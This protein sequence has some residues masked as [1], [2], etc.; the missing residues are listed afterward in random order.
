MRNSRMTTIATIAAAVSFGSRRLMKSTFR[1]DFDSNGMQII[2]DHEFGF[3]KETL[4]APVP[5][6]AIMLG[7]TPPPPR[8]K[9]ASYCFGLFFGFHPH[10]WLL[11]AYDSRD[12]LRARWSASVKGFG[13]RLLRRLG[14]RR[15]RRSKASQGGNRGEVGGPFGER[16]YGDLRIADGWRARR[17]RSATLGIFSGSADGWGF[18]WRRCAGGRRWPRSQEDLRPRPGVALVFRRAAGGGGDRRCAAGCG[19]TVMSCRS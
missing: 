12:V 7:R 15:G 17:L 18:R 19:A 4:V 13:R 11:M 6:V 3:L 2:W 8:Y 5:R 14:V 1:P 10:S 16:A 9:A